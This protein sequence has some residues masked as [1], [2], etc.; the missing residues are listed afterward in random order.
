MKKYT[1]HVIHNMLVKISGKRDEPISGSPAMDCPYYINLEGILGM[2]WGI[3]VNPESNKF[4]QLVFEH[5]WCGCE[6]ENFDRVKHDDE[7]YQEIEDAW[8]EKQSIP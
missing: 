8:K 7:N 5:D 2:D 1:H 3:I 6:D 4:G